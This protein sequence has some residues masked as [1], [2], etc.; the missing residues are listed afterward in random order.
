DR[1]AGRRTELDAGW[2][3]LTRVAQSV[4]GAPRIERGVEVRLDTPEPDLS[5]PRTRLA[6]GRFALVEFPYFT[7]PPRSVTVL[8]ALRA[9]DVVPV[10]A[11]PERYRGMREQ[12]DVARE[13][14]EAGA[15]L[16]LNGPSLLGRYG[17]EVKAAALLLL[18]KGLVD[19]VSSDYHAR[20]RTEIAAYAEVLQ[21]LVGEEAAD[22][23]LR[24]N[25][26]RLLEGE[27]P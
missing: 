11:H 19:Y 6:G 25:A 14:K 9:Q 17:G 20:G 18:N 5:D 10:I 24:G 26:A 3:E 7:I 22:W 4:P 27:P 12:V 21:E 8:D 13:W 16:Q 23:L 15:F 2:A 1:G